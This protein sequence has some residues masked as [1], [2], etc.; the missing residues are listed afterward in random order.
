M[1]A[2]KRTW[3]VVADAASAKILTLEGAQTDQDPAIGATFENPAVHGHSRDLVSDKPGRA[4]ESMGTMRHAQE[5]KTD[6]HRQ[7]KLAIARDI[8]AYL[9]RANNEHKFDELV[10][11]APPTTLGDLRA[12]LDKAVAKRVAGEIGKDV[13]KLPA[14]DVVAQVRAVLRP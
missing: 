13:T 12:V 3:V 11:V 1:P 2:K 6:P 9:A 14:S 5:P 8:A 7:A 10:L 4:M